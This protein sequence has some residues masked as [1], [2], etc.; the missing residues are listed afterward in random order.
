MRRTAAEGRGAYR[1]IAGILL[2]AGL[3]SRFGRQ[4]LLE[5]WHGEPLLRHAARSWIEAALSPVVVVLSRDR[6]LSN[7][8][9]DLAV[10]RVE[11]PAPERGISSS[12]ALGLHA[13]G[14]DVSSV[15]IGV[16]DQPH[17]SADGLRR[18]MAAF[19]AGRIIVPRYDDHRGNP[20]IFD[21]GFFPELLALDGDRG[22][23]QIVGRHAADVIEVRLPAIMG[24]DVDRP[25][26]WPR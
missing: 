19:Q 13:L 6:R 23:Q 14:E 21:R 3:S 11:N 1:L 8:L 9:A 26:D 7:A 25:E 24:E 15:L 18:L 22:G 4:K 16:A 10:E 12:I 2:A 17:L 20:V 5:P